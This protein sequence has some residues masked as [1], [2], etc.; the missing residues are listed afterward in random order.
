MKKTII[1]AAVLSAFLV[2]CGSSQTPVAAD[3]VEVTE[4]GIATDEGEE[5]S[6]TRVYYCKVE[7]IDEKYVTLKSEEAT[8]KISV[9][10]NEGVWVGE[11]LILECREDAFEEESEG[12]Y[13]VKE[14]L[15]APIFVD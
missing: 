10:G 14:G 1:A 4:S 11:D 15:L 12:T 5:M 2:G 7:A 3:Y 9:K 6:N 13:L 8:Y